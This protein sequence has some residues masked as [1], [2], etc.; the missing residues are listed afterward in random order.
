ME[1]VG[2]Y[3]L[4]ISPKYRRR[5]NDINLLLSD[6]KKIDII[7]RKFSKNYEIYPELSDTG[8]LH[9]HGYMTIDDII[10]YKRIIN[11]LRYIGFVKIETKLRNKMKWMDY[12]K[13]DIDST[14]K[15]FEVGALLLPLKRETLREYKK[16]CERIE[17]QELKDSSAF[18]QILRIVP[19]A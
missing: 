17:E 19:R 6:Y 14:S 9:Y 8:R 11:S 15:I 16:E 10:K 12:C 3:G 1:N 2:F 5:I 7:I 18:N 13:K 4:T